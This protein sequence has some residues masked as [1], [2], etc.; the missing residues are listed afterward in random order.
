MQIGN[1]LAPQLSFGA[2]KRKPNPIAPQDQ[3]ALRVGLDTFLERRFLSGQDAIDIA[4][5][6]G[7]QSGL[8][9]RIKQILNIGAV[10]TAPNWRARGVRAKLSDG[11]S[12]DGK[13]PRF[14]S[15]STIDGAFV[16]LAKAISNKTLECQNRLTSH[17]ESYQIN[18]RVPN[19]LELGRKVLAK[20]AKKA[21]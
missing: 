16:A 5:M 8:P 9:Y 2:K 6:N 7:R 15:A 19:L 10:A 1:F 13:Y 17:L 18:L 3:H 20:R 12:I 4:K 14:K 21:K 11:I